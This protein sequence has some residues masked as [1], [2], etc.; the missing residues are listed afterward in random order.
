[1]LRNARP[2][3]STACGKGY[4]YGCTVSGIIQASSSKQTINHDTT[5]VRRKTLVPHP[6]F[7]YR[8][9]IPLKPCTVYLV[10][11]PHI[12]TP[13]YA[14]QNSTNNSPSSPSPPM[15]SSLD[16]HAEAVLALGRAVLR[17]VRAVHRRAGAVHAVPAADGIRAQL[18]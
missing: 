12:S 18:L 6:F 11:R 4:S 7:D 5:L 13:R 2:S 8:H 9:N 1:M 14:L 15:Q 10:S 3:S 17:Q 16:H